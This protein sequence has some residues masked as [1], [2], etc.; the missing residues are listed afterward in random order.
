MC[1]GQ[2]K[3]QAWENLLQETGFFS[4]SLMAKAYSRMV[5]RKTKGRKSGHMHPDGQLPPAL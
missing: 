3:L 4:L 5:L 1:S 2:R